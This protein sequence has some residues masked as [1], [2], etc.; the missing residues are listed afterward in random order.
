MLSKSLNEVSSKL[1]RDTSV[2]VHGT[3]TEPRAL[4]ENWV[5]NPSH[6]R[7]VR[8]LTSFIPGV[9]TYK[10]AGLARDQHIVA[11]MNHSAYADA[12]ASGQLTALRLSYSELGRYIA[13]SPRL[14]T[15]FVQVAPMKNGRYS[16]GISAS[17]IPAAV[18]NADKICAI[19]ND[20][21][22]TPLNG[23]SLSAD[24]VDYSV[25]VSRPLIE[26]AAGARAPDPVSLQIA[27]HV[28]S[29][30]K[31]GDTLQA[32]LGAVPAAL[33]RKLSKHRGLRVYGGMVTDAFASM[34]DSGALDM[35][36][37]HIYGMALGSREFYQ[38]LDGRTG[39]RVA[40]VEETHSV[41]RISS[42]ENFVAVNS[43]ISV[44]LDGAVNAERVG[45]R[46]VSGPGGLPDF[47]AGASLSAGGRSIIALP[48]TNTRGTISR[49]TSK[50]VD[51]MAR[52]VIAEYITHVVT[53]FG[54]ADLRGASSSE[55]ACR[56][57]D[58][59][60]PKFRNSLSLLAEE[61]TR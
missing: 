28:C 24:R 14:D 48:A 1:R 13:E 25:N 22:P 38:W 18:A 8:V 54:I 23:F 5:A 59:A 43:A 45:D 56:L 20:Q 50:A 26:Y 6:L 55:R 41:E 35:S 34:Y 3:A 37:E 17:L 53:E 46:C 15:A 60:N 61:T 19:V 9:N 33:F 31:D 57:I 51:P 21:M 12:E 52:T 40:G 36:I 58:I 44:G 10:L 42:I 11:F 32:G 27:E 47:T 49:I 29:L 2:F 7:G 30:V 16:T 4:L 39:C